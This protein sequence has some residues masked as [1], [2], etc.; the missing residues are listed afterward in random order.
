MVDGIMLAIAAGSLLYICVSDI[1]I[2]EF[3][4]KSS[5]WRKF[6]CLFTGMAVENSLWFIELSQGLDDS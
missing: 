2:K 6:I 1:L 3:S 5:N 4:L